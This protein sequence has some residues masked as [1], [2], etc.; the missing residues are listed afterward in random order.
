VRGVKRLAVLVLFLAC[1]PPP[2]PPAPPPAQYIHTT[3]RALGGLSMGAIGTA[4]VGLRHPDRFD[5]LAAEGGPLDVPMLLRMLDDRFVGG[6]C[7]RA[8]LEAVDPARLNDPTA[9]EGCV[10]LPPTI[11]YEHQEDYA[12]LFYSV[13]APFDRPTYFGLF[14]DLTLA[15]GNLLTQNPD[16]PFAPPGTDAQHMLHPP[17]DFCTKPLVVHGLL[18]A[19]YNA[20]GKYDA[21]TFCDDEQ[22]IYVCNSDQSVVDFCS[23][24]ANLVTPVPRAGEAAFANTFCASKG[25]AIVATDPEI[26]YHH[27]GIYDPCREQHTPVQVALAFDI[28]GN[29]KRD[30]GEPLLDNGQE[31]FQD[32]GVDG[33]PDARE[34][35]KGGCTTTDNPAAVDPNGDN[36]DAL[37]NPLGTES[38]WYHDDGEPFDDN[39]LDGVPGTNDVGEGNGMFDMTEGRKALWAHDAR[40]LLKALG[41]DGLARLHLL[42]DGGIHDT[43][44]FGLTSQQVYGLYQHLHPDST[45]RYRDFAD[46]PGMK[47]SRTGAFN[48]WTAMGW[49]HAPK[50]LFVLYG[51]DDATEQDLLDGD[52]DHVGTAAQA[53]ARISMLYGWVAAQW[54]SLPRPSTASDGKT[55][56]ERQQTTWFQST[57]LQAK[58]GFGIYVPPGYFLP[59]NADVRYPVLVL[60]HGYQG[61]E[62]QIL[63]STLL[64]D[65]YM[66][67]SDVKLTPM[68]VVTPSGACCFTNASTGGRDCREKNDQGTY[69]TAIPGW[70]REC[71]GGSFFFD[72]LVTG[73]AYEASMLELMDYVDT[74]Y[75]TLP[76]REVLAR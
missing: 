54:P 48:P 46:I 61:D 64:A 37:T 74:N 42:L 7:S 34:D 8:D 76:P 27:G 15:F 39:G 41:P 62:S 10:H 6:F 38:N 56:D 28:N 17:A 16:S 12:H 72:Q 18:N 45:Q 20:D 57:A 71:V 22:T 31:R 58:R 24:P 66:S 49:Q 44:N 69:F 13:N 43:F 1:S 11:Q 9:V 40:S 21:V 14:T 75:R 26:L 55:Y 73:S 29:G 60:L 50:N 3:Y 25:G 32:V 19:E 67:D 63:P 23:N 59:E 53:V 65:T 68:I 35:G 36:Y 33:C 5:A 30:Y 52:G 51:K 70:E 2:S 4:G 47:D